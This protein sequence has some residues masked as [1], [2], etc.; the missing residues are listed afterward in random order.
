MSSTLRTIPIESGPLGVFGGTFDPVHNAHLHLAAEAMRLLPLAGILW[1]PANRPAHRQSPI[2]SAAD[3][4]AMV[5]LAI[6]GHPDYRIDDREFADD[7]PTYTVPT[8][9]RLRTEYG[10][11]KPLVLLLG[12]DAFLKLDTWHRWPE[13]F[14]LAHIAIV[15]R[16]GY[17]L[18]PRTMD[19]SLA[20]QFKD[21]HRTDSAALTETV[22]GAIHTYT[23][24]AGTVSSTGVRRTL[25]AGLPVTELLPAPVVDYIVA[26]R[27]YL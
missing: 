10:D 7:T 13:L 22:A 6:A 9:E 18:D 3:R 27:L 17:P 20:E 11:R 1:I 19:P 4:L 15:S 25:A 16:P 12:A 24:D 26:H 2:A 5:R 21:R 23:M 14:R 8:L